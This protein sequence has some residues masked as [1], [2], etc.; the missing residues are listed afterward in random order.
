LYGSYCIVLHVYQCDR[1]A[2]TQKRI[3][4]FRAG[5][6]LQ[7]QNSKLD[8]GGR[9]RA[10]LVSTSKAKPST[11]YFVRNYLGKFQGKDRREMVSFWRTTSVCHFAPLF[12]LAHCTQTPYSAHKLL[13][14]KFTHHTH[15][16]AHTHM[17]T[18]FARRQYDVRCS[19]LR[20]KGSRTLQVNASVERGGEEE[21]SCI[22]FTVR[23]SR[24]RPKGSRT[25]QVNASVERGGEEEFSC[26][27]FTVAVCMCMEWTTG[28]NAKT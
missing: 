26:I 5:R 13:E 4:P 17:G 16:H 28:P 6:V 15:V 21:F 2:L 18:S 23:C 9:C 24:L 20:P 1:K 11:V 14:S 22:E 12:Y 8:H 19:R 7:P 27:E 10:L 3:G 25:L